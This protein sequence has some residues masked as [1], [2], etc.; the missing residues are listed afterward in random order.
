MIRPFVWYIRDGLLMLGPDIVASGYSGKRPFLNDPLATD[1]QGQGPIP[2]GHWRIGIAVNHS[3][4]GPFSI[5]LHPVTYQ[6]PRSAFYI[7]GDN[8]KGDRSA[9]SGC[10]I[11]PRE[12]RLWIM[13]R[14]TEGNTALLVVA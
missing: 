5:A 4:L 10:I 14:A 3:K 9:S 13:A 7:H 8:D 1:R 12:R 2:F 6:G 11:L